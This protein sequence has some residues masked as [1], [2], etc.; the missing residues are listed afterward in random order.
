MTVDPTA[1]RSEHLA[2]EHFDRRFSSENV[3]FWV[4]LLIEIGEIRAGAT[5]LDVGC[6]T[7]GFALALAERGGATVIGLERSPAFLDHARALPPP[8]CGSVEW[9]AGDAEAVPLADASVDTVLVSLVLHQLA[10]PQRAVAEARR[11]LRPGGVAVVR[12]IAPEDAAERVPARYL[13][14]M[15]AADVGRLPRLETIER[16]L[17]DV[18]F[19]K[20]ERRRVLRNQRL[21]LADQER[22]LL[23]DVHGRYAFIPEAEVA[24]GLERMRAD[25]HGARNEWVDPR[26]TWFLRACR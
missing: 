14:S 7:G 2:T 22:D 5:V 11:V 1:F 17:A 25:A 24:A 15:A 19:R 12:T 13:P 16:W 10:E 26:P 4:P 23:A 9:L 20:L 8:A 3:A 18:G 21:D 6:G